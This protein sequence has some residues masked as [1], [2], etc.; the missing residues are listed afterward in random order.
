MV[1]QSTGCDQQPTRSAATH[2]RTKRNFPN[3]SFGL[4]LARLQ[5]RASRA[6]LIV[7]Q[8]ADASVF[9]E[10]HGERGTEDWVVALE[11]D[12]LAHLPCYNPISLEWLT[13]KRGFARA[14]V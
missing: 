11:R 13:I 8:H 12:C 2:R 10:I 9:S 5:R 1:S 14:G 7:H 4:R 3:V 6:A